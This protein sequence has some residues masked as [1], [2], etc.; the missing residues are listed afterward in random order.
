MRYRKLDENGDMTFGGGMLNYYVNQPEAVAQAVS[1]RLR[2]WVE[3]WFVDITEGTPWVQSALGKRTEQTVTNAIRMRILKTQGVNKI[4]DFSF[5][6]NA[7][8]RSVVISATI[9]TIYGEAQLF[10][11]L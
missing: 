2:L 5:S 11:V 6:Q 9:D 3:E 8:D 1:T 4:T 7:S 10:E